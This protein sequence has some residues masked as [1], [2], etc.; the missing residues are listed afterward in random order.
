MFCMNA[1]ID[2]ARVYE[3]EA[4]DLTVRAKIDADPLGAARFTD[5]RESPVTFMKPFSPKDPGRGAALVLTRQGRG[6]LY[7]RAGLSFSPRTPQSEPVNAGL[8]IHREYSV[9]RGGK[10]QLLKDPMKIV[11]GELV[12]VD[13]FVSLPAARNFVVVEDPV[14]GGLEPVNRDLATGSRVDAEKG[15]FVH[16]GGSWWFHYGEWSSYGVSRWSFYHRELRHDAARFYS[17]YL[18]AGNY[19]LSYT[20]QAIAA[21]RFYVPPARAEE[22]YTPDVFGKG[23]PCEL[24]VSLEQAGK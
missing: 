13:L 12:R 1:L 6:R 15:A 19:D 20:A 2:Y 21:G 16:E 24:R 5:P 10:W 17:E 22:M 3:S 7:Y 23:A 9:E 18:P 8:E 4:P 14:P 11:R